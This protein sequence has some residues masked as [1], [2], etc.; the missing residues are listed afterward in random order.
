M[1]RFPPPWTL[2]QIKAA[3]RCLILTANLSLTSMGVRQKVLALSC[4]FGD[5]E[6]AEIGSLFRGSFSPEDE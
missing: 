5:D 6:V 4:L 1:R 3:I 2:E